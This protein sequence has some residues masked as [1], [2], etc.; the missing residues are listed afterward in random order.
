MKRRGGALA[1]DREIW[2]ARMRKALAR[3]QHNV[4]QRMVKRA[5]RLKNPTR[6]TVCRT[7]KLPTVITLTSLVKVRLAN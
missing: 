7:L 4:L 1:V 2:R 5:K 3:E 6:G